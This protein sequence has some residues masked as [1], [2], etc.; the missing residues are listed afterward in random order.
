MT[1]IIIT[2]SGND[3][4][5]IWGIACASRAAAHKLLEDH[6]DYFRRPG[7]EGGYRD[8]IVADDPDGVEAI[9]EQDFLADL[10]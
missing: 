5:H 9:S 1:T 8:V 4:A 2:D 3:E 7:P 6:A 10:I